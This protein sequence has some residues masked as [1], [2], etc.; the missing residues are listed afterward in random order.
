MKKKTVLI[1]AAGGSLFP[2]LIKTLGNDYRL[3]L[4]DTLDAI[5]RLYPDKLFIKVPL[6]DS[7][8]F[9]TEVRKIIDDYHVNYYIPLI[10]KEISKVLAIGREIKS[11]K[12]ISPNLEF[13][14]LCL[15]KYRLMKVLEESKISRIKTCIGNDF[16]EDFGFPVF[17]KP[18]A[19]T[20]SRGARKIDNIDQFEA[21]FKLEEFKKDQ[22][23]VQEFLTGEE[24][25]VSVTVNNLNSLMAIVPKRIVTKKGITIHA[26][27]QRNQAIVKAC[28]KIVDQFRP[29]GPFN[30]QLMLV[31]DEVKI[32]EINPRFSTT[33]ILTCEAGI[34]EF[35]M[36]IESY[37]RNKVSFVDSYRE[38]LFLYRRW[39]SCFY[40]GK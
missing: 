16:K 40:E 4:T 28:R 18:I 35:A 32:F 22:V 31:V 6:A 37:D 36:C 24:Y 11:L 33:S 15:D 17:I 7:A 14:N 23:M 1:S 19:N 34:D 3:I 26:F 29:A 20:G 30:V 39:E 21:Y 2:Y 25:T 12:V 13:V 27:T 9:K 5:R 8:D 38:N 10:D